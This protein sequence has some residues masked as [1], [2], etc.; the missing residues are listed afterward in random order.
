MPFSDELRS[1]RFG[2]EIHKIFGWNRGERTRLPWGGLHRRNPQDLPSDLEGFRWG[3][4]KGSE[5]MASPA[6]NC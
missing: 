2:D 6:K 5:R 1:S 4:E 3:F